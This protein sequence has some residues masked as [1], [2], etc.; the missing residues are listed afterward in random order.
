MLR[1]IQQIIDA[2]LVSMGHIRL[3]QPLPAAG[4][5]QWSPF[6]LLHHFDLELE[7]GDTRFDVPPHPHRGFMPITFMY[8]GAVE[9]QDS[10]GN[11]QVIGPDE[12]QW[13]N[14]ARGIIHA[15]R[16]GREFALQG[17]RFQG[18]QLW[19]NLPASEKMK[20]PRYEAL[21]TDRM[22]V[23]QENGA[24]LRLV[25]GAYQGKKGPATSSV[26]TAMI[27]MEP[28]GDLRLDLPANEHAFLYILEGQVKV[29]DSPA[30]AHQLLTFGPSSGTITLQGDTRASLLLGSGRPIEEPLVSHGPFVMNSQTE[31]MEA[32]RDY[33][34]GKMGFLY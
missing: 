16:T 28:A 19:I 5:R 10:L 14:A 18:I 7:P 33:Q 2:P 11:S 29:N 15:E 23:L 3:R 21:T 32:M 34:D 25:S 8:D 4:L 26:L 6:I 20:T 13:I 22:V 9:H 31:I 12:V 1:D 30:H 17:G 24:T 27:R